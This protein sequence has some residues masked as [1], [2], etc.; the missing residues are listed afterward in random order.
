M[1][2]TLQRQ[3]REHPNIPHLK[4]QLTALRKEITQELAQE[5]E[6]RLQREI[7][8]MDPRKSK[9]FWK[10]FNE[11]IRTDKK[12]RQQVTLTDPATG[13]KTTSNIENATLFA[14][15]LENVHKTHRDNY[16][17]HD[18]KQEVDRWAKEHTH[19]FNP[20]ETPQFMQDEYSRP[21]TSDEL[22]RTLKKLNYKSTP[23][24]DTIPYTAIRE[25]PVNTKNHLLHIYNI[26]FT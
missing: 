22:T 16:M 7:A 13:N 2:Q 21:F 18:H 11:A 15:H 9:S 14:N 5:K 25:L 20:T 10:T 4:T 6:T 3:A 17:D 23:G 1:K 8:G 12:D 24:E 19:L 26:C